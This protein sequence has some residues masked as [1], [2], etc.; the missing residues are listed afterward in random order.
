MPCSVPATRYKNDYVG[1]F[2]S[3]G[4]RNARKLLNMAQ[5]SKT[6]SPVGRMTK[7]VHR[8]CTEEQ[9]CKKKGAFNYCAVTFLCLKGTCKV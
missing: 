1:G 6:L 5:G 8:F 9:F 4:N 7:R 3:L 2:S